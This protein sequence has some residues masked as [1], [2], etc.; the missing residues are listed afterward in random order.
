MKTKVIVMCVLAAVLAIG[1][2]AQAT[3][4]VVSVTG[5]ADSTTMGYTEG[6]SYTFNWTINDGYDGSGSG[7][8]D[9]WCNMWMV[10]DTSDPLLWS[11]VSGD[12]LSGTYSRPSGSSWAPYDLFQADSFGLSLLAG[13]M[14]AQSS[15]QGLTVNGVELLELYVDS[16]TADELNL[17]YSDTSFVNPATW[18]AEYAG[19]YNSGVSAESFYVCDEDNNMTN[20]TA[21]SF[22]IA[23][24]PEP[25]T[26]CLLGIGGLFLRRRKRA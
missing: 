16:L 12:G 26:M 8:F 6:E 20:F 9:S 11:D 3:P 5:T 22:E 1:S 23:A 19:T 15:S 2:A 13:N 17:D 4:I 7:C 10:E 18:A 21:T 25:A 14:N 24:V